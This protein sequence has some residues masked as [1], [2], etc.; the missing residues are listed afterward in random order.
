MVTDPA[1]SWLLLIYSVPP[2]PSA[3]RVSIW[4]KLKRLGARLPHD[5]VWVLPYAT[6]TT[7]QL[8]WLASDIRGTG[9]VQDPA[10]RPTA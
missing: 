3:N 1:D 8:Q 2:E 7:A 5:A 4:R 6:R 9:R 10:K